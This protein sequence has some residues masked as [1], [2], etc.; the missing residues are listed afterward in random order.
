MQH[1]RTDELILHLSLNRITFLSYK[2]KRILSKKL[3]SSYSL[4]LLSIEEICKIINRSINNRVKWDGKENLRMAELSAHYCD[5]LGV[6]IILSSDEDY[7]YLLKQ[8]SDPPYLLFCRGDHE[9]LNR[10]TVSVVGTR[11]LTPAGKAA[12]HSFAYDA[13]LNGMNVVSGLAAGADGAAHQ[14]CLDAFFDC[15]ERGIDTAATGKTVAVLPSS[16]DEVVPY[17]HKRMASQVLKCGGCLLSEYEPG[18]SMASWHFVARNRIIAGLSQATVVIEAPPGSGALITADFALDYNREVFFHKAA[19]G[20]AAQKLAHNVH[21]QLEKDHATGQVSRYK[22][23]NRPERYLDAGAP[24]VSS[25]A[26]FV[27]QASGQ[28]PQNSGQKASGCVQN[29]QGE[30]F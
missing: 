9:I 27:L 7:P 2:E 13:S 21:C 4:A 11:R 10:K 20:D 12:A 14:G 22:L 16:I 24:V 1:L 25:F 29:F 30:L 8:I 18:M 23:E 19:F 17:A 6:K 26:D 28:K 5:V 15:Q 3:D